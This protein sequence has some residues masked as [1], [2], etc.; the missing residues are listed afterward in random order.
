MKLLKSFLTISG[1]CTFSF[2]MSFIVKLSGNGVFCASSI[3]DLKA[4]ATPLTFVSTLHFMLA[5]LLK[6]SSSVI[7]LLN[8]TLSPL[9]FPLRILFCL[10]TVLKALSQAFEL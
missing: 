9:F 2:A 3:C 10:Q 8:I 6:A 4:N 5:S 7:E 1:T